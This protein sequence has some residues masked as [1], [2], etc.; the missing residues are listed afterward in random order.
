MGYAAS[1]SDSSLFIQKGLK[2]HVCI[3]L[4]VDDLVVSKPNLIEISQVQSQLPEAFEMDLGDLSYFLGIK[5]IHTPDG[6]LL[7]Q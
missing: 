4:Y 7:S 1:K 2:G 5:V 6:I 3:L